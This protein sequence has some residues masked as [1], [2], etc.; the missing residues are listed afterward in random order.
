M[1]RS[2]T[3]L[4]ATEAECQRTIVHG[5]RLCG[6]YVH[7]NRPAQMRSGRW[8][9]PIIG[10]V[11]FPDLVL[12]HPVAG[13]W[14]VEL[15][16]RPNKLTDEQRAWGVALGAFATWRCVWV[17]DELDAFVQELADVTRV[18]AA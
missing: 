17:P 9:T 6:W 4:R 13:L 3:D 18:P 14:F 15:K 10:H 16:R 7:H 5:A 8:S 11:G 2:A 1:N 12:V